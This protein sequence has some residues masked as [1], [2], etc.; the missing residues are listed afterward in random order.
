MFLFGDIVALAIQIEQNAEKAFREAAN[1]TSAPSLASLLKWLADEEVGHAKRLSELKPK[2]KETAL[3]PQAKALG[4]NL[5]HGI[6]GNQTFSLKDADLT[7]MD[8]EQGLLI[9][10]I[11]FEQ[12]TVLFYE[13][14]R[15]FVEEKEN[16]ALLDTIIEEEHSH[17]KLLQEFVENGCSP[18]DQ[19]KPN[20]E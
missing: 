17:I 11:E 4:K 10:A 15:S 2:G 19:G 20:S 6:L 12:D 13:M 8:Q 16:L 5:L 9:A 18:A 7:K 3:D 1:N 14:L